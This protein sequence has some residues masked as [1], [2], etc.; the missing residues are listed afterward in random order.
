MQSKVEA[1]CPQCREEDSLSM[2]AMNSEIPYFG[3][4]TQITVMCASCGWKHTDFIPSD[5]EK[6]GFSSIVVDSTEK[7][8]ARVVRSSSC[9]IRIPELDLEVSPGSSSS[10][11]VTNIEGVIKRFEEAIRT[12]I[13]GNDDYEDGQIAEQILVRLE[14]AKSG[15]DAIRVD[16]LDPRGRSQIIHED[17][18]SRELN[19]I[20]QESLETGPDVPVFEIG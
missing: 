6:P 20:E 18:E 16:L 14:L 2:L 12:V 1:P 3:E 4:H 11:F 17:A 8:A 13:R 7:T 10:G 5:G 9:T 19:E 15:A